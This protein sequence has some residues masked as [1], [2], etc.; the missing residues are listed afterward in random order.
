MEAGARG[1]APEF[2]DFR[3][4]AQALLPSLDSSSLWSFSSSSLGAAP[5]TAVTLISQISLCMAESR[6]QRQARAK[7]ESGEW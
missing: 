5:K 6:M 3:S 7:F 4:L 2:S 1:S